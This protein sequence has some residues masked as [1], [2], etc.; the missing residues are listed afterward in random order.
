MNIRPFLL[1]LWLSM[2]LYAENNYK[3][4][5]YK[6]CID[7][8]PVG[9]LIAYDSD[10]ELDRQYDS[11][12][13]VRKAA[14]WSI[15]DCSNI[16]ADKNGR[17]AISQ[18]VFRSKVFKNAN[19]TEIIVGSRVVVN[20]GPEVAS[21]EIESLLSDAGLVMV[22][23]LFDETNTFVCS[24]GCKDGDEVL[25]LANSL[26]VVDE[27][28]FSEPEMFV[29]GH[30]DSLEYPDSSRCWALH[31]D[32]TAYGYEDADMDVVQAWEYTKGSSDIIVAVLDCGVSLG[33]PDLDV[34]YAKDF[35]Y[36]AGDGGVVDASLDLHATMVAGCVAAKLNG[37]G[38]TGVAPECL[39]ASA[40]IMDSQ[41]NNTGLYSPIWVS[42]ALN[43]SYT[44]G[45]RVTVNSNSFGSTSSIIDL[46][47][48]TARNRGIICFA[49]AGNDSTNQIAYP[50]SL[51]TVNSVAASTYYNGLA[52]FSCYGTGLAFTAPGYYIYT[53]AVGG[54]YTTSHGT[55]FS[56]PYAAGVA[57]LVLS[58]D[59]SLTP[60]EVEAIMQ[61]SAA[62]LGSSG[63]DT[64][65]GYGLVN[66]YHAVVLAATGACKPS[67]INRDRIVNLQD[68]ADIQLAYSGTETDITTVDL[69]C[70]GTIDLDDLSLLVNQWLT[71]D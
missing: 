43:W 7:L 33:H 29:F 49:S 52:S 54:G 28:V 24:S 62:D 20:F 22:E 63:Y 66:A 23:R 40:R 34:A 70:S 56:C 48:Q 68:Y 12:K 3:Y 64:T 10:L 27:I 15:A 8:K 5:Y 41:G 44:I 32:G 9:G 36:D 2:A 31:N 50:S 26:A 42:N 39:L 37:T 13:V 47:Y 69:D 25:E 53:T 11:G 6:D 18:D 61:S 16:I 60:A 38:T 14:N 65:Y 67:D 45:A 21:S 55:S 35:T 46:A 1:L 30:S 4:M 71:T 17:E 19:G 57:A 58:I 51:G 59:N